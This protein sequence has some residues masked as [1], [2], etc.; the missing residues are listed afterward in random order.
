LFVTFNP[1]VLLA[2]IVKALLPL[3][4]EL[5]VFAKVKSPYR[6]ATE[7]FTVMFVAGAGVAP[8][9]VNCSAKLILREKRIGI[10]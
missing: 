5:L 4:S 7:P 3:L 10:G 8:L 9:T 6:S 2:M 1:F